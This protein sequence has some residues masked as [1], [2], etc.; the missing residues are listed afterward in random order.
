MFSNIPCEWNNNN[1]VSQTRIERCLLDHYHAKINYIRISHKGQNTAAVFG[2]Q[3]VSRACRNALCDHMRRQNCNHSTAWKQGPPAR[4]RLVA[5]SLTGLVHIDT[6]ASVRLTSTVTQI[7]GDSSGIVKCNRNLAIGVSHCPW[8][9]QPGQ[10]PTREFKLSSEER[11]TSLFS[12]Y[13]FEYHTYL[14]KV[15][16]VDRLS[17]DDGWRQ[18][19]W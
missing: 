4:T 7:C 12:T 19:A 16:V 5:L 3:G 17:G 9:H 15:T 13:K 18:T 11:I 8:P 10:N 1:F 2:S 6:R 14:P